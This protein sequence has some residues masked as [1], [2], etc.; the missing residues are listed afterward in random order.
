MGSE[1]LIF[2]KKNKLLGKIDLP[3][4]KPQYDR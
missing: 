1:A 2:N 3:G 4:L